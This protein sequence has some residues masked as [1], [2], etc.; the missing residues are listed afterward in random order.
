MTRTSRLGR[1]RSENRRTGLERGS[2]ERNGKGTPPNATEDVALEIVP[3]VPVRAIPGA[4]EAPQVL[5]N[6][7]NLKSYQCS[8]SLPIYI[9]Y[10]M[11]Y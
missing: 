8:L 2:N 1:M 10:S 6:E 4:P 5:I 7:S 9:T 11:G 3:V